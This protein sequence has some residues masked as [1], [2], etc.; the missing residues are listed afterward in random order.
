MGQISRKVR[1]ASAAY[2]PLAVFA[3]FVGLVFVLQLVGLMVLVDLALR[4]FASPY[5]D[6]GP[7]VAELYQ[8]RIMN[9]PRPRD[10]PEPWFGARA[11][12]AGADDVDR[13]AVLIREELAK[14][15]GSALRRVPVRRVVLCANLSVDGR[16]LGGLTLGGAGVILLDVGRP[17][18]LG[19]EVLRHS[20]HHE[21]SHAL[22][23]TFR[24]DVGRDD[25]WSR[26]N[27][28]GFRYGGEEIVRALEVLGED[29][30]E[31]PEAPGFLTYYAMASPGEDRAEVF[32]AMMTHPEELGLVAG[33]DPILAAKC[34]L[35]RSELVGRDQGFAAVLDD[36][37]LPP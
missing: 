6:D 1:P 18:P 35:L 34:K 11:E 29:P 36:P 27:P 17:G 3:A 21:M 5:E 33:E 14:Y 9:H 16:P 23:D 24:R 15:G 26:L 7:V 12:P 19:R 30:R 37:G 10:R 31:R 25:R 32:A 4:M 2:F 22:D 20:L 8:V 13:V 28:A